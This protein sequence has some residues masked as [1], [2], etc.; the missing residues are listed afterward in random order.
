VFAFLPFALLACGGG[1]ASPS[2]DSA[3]SEP[4]TRDSS[5]GVTDTGIACLPD[6][7]A[8]L[9]SIAAECCEL[10][11]SLQIL[12]GE[13]YPEDLEEGGNLPL[14]YSPQYGWELQL[15]PKIC[16]TR[17]EVTTTVTL[18]D[19]ETGSTVQ[20][21]TVASYLYQD[22]EGSCC[23]DTW[24]RYERLDV[25]FIPGHQGRNFAEAMCDR[26]VTLTIT[27]TDWDGRTVS[28]TLGLTMTANEEAMGHPCNPDRGDTGD[29]P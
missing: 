26:A 17:D 24:M 20:Q 19:V 12:G 27:A 6:D 21:D 18:L 4:S 5:T 1:T 14:A 9:G 23:A 28:E 7:T 11:P 22:A 3:V 8:G 10:P 16:G 13:G 29:R 15:F 25:R 2:T